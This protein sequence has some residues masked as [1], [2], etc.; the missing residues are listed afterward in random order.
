[1]RKRINTHTHRLTNSTHL[2]H[3]HDVVDG[4][5]HQ[6]LVLIPVRPP[7]LLPAP[8]AVAVLVVVVVVVG[9][10]PNG[11][12]L[13]L[14]GPH[15]RSPMQY[16]TSHGYHRPTYTHIYTHITYSRPPAERTGRSPRLP[17]AG[18]R[19]RRPPLP[20]HVV[21]RYRS[22]RRRTRDPY[23]HRNIPTP[24][25]KPPTSPPSPNT[26]MKVHAASVAMPRK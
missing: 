23:V 3:L 5:G 18:C 19:A 8:S 17:P 24:I 10:R 25:Q 2:E 11:L 16:N 9:F 22:G 13:G 6:L 7:P 26:I 15:A 1:V 20:H 14:R 12:V 4:V 21:D